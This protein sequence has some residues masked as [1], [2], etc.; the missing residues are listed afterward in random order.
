MPHHDDLEEMPS[1]GLWEMQFH[2][3]PEGRF[4]AH[5]LDDLSSFKEG[6]DSPS[7]ER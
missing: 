4:E 6:L 2:A 3:G 5:D 7:F 1:T